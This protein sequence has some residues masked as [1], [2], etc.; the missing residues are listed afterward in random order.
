MLLEQ[1][2]G[3]NGEIFTNLQQVNTIAAIPSDVTIKQIK[4]N[5]LRSY[6]RL[7]DLP[8]FKQ[9]KKDPIA[10]VGGGPSLESQL[11]KLKEFKNVMVCGSAHDY[12][13]EQGFVPTYTVICDPDAI[14]A[15]YVSK[16]NIFTKYLV[17]T[18]CH[19]KVYNTLEG[20]LIY[21]WHCFSDDHLK[22]SDE[23]ESDYQAIGGGC[24]VGLRSLSIALMLGYSDIHFFGFDSCLGKD[25][26][27]HAYGFTDLEKEKLGEIYEVRVGNIDNIKENKLFYCAGYQLAQCVHFKDFY[28]RY[29][30]LFEPIFHGEGLLTE[31]MKIINSERDKLCRETGTT[32]EQEIQKNRAVRL[33]KLK[34][35]LETAK[36]QIL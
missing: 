12:I 18:G 15:N 30:S 32:L 17:S 14:S 9:I 25:S 29:N 28:A 1:Q 10:L 31:S 5:I 11:N 22:T 23:I 2:V 13:I 3:S 34:G 19:D 4:R 26:K 7:H 20:C 8:E 27:H 35:A 36:G 33:E 6:A 21:M 16:P 24:T